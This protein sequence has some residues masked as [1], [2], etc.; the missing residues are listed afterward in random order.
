M[1]PWIY[2]GKEQRSQ[3]E[4]VK[5]RLSGTIKKE[6]TSAKSPEV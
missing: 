1:F 2:D 5:E 3:K 6:Q 4:I